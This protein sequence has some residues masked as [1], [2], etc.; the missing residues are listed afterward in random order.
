MQ[1]DAVARF[2]GNVGPGF[3]LARV[4]YNY[5]RL[6]KFQADRDLITDLLK[7]VTVTIHSEINGLGFPAYA[8]ALAQS[9]RQLPLEAPPCG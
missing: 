5:A 1:G 9:L 7:S 3:A 4:A 2:T 6:I 8:A